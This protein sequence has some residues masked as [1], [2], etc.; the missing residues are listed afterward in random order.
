M[1]SYF[2][3]LDAKAGNLR[4]SPSRNGA[5]DQGWNYT[6]QGINGA[7]TRRTTLPGAKVEID[8]V[9]TSIQF[10]GQASPNSYRI[11]VNGSSPVSGQPQGDLLG[12]IEGLDI[13]NHTVSLEVTNGA[14]EIGITRVEVYL[15]LGQ[16]K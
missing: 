3:K 4:F 13:G 9:G 6:A 11:S 14:S 16:A 7:A 8:F 1:S 15:A 5:I 2:A 12:G 10:F